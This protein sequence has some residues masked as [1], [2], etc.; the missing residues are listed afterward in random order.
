MGCICMGQRLNVCLSDRDFKQK[1]TW[2]NLIL[3]VSNW[4]KKKWTEVNILRQI[5]SVN[6]LGYSQWKY[7]KNQKLFLHVGISVSFW[8]YKT[9]KDKDQTSYCNFYNQKKR[10]NKCSMS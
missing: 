4:I 1:K 9:L 8:G 3:E 2:T 5:H 6:F 10:L 7:I